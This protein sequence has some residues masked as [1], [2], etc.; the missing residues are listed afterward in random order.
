MK[1]SQP[2]RQNDQLTPFSYG[3]QTVRAEL[4]DG[5]PWFVAKDVCDALGLGNPSQTTSRFPK[6]ETTII[7]TDSGS[8]KHYLILVNEP[9]LYRLIFQSRKP[10]A[11]R[12]KTWAFTEVLPQIRRTGAY[13]HDDGQE[14][15]LRMAGFI[16]SR[17]IGCPDMTIQKINRLVY[18]L[19][20]RPPLTQSDIA[21]LLGVNPTNV[22]EWKRRLPMDIIERAA[23]VLAL[24][25]SGDAPAL[26]PRVPRRRAIQE[27]AI[28]P[29]DR[30]GFP[31][32][33]PEKAAAK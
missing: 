1:T 13:V 7:S 5:N 17:F 14:E 6:E 21:K 31:L 4:I 15:V 30:P 26:G 3:D 25:V 16:Y 29:S 19:A 28:A 10:E 32:A 9:G 8:T 12:F 33:L 23:S 24:T 18:Y 22:L 2:E 11:E 20:V 27:A